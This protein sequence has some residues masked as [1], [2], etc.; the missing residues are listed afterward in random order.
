M[1]MFRVSN[2]THLPAIECQQLHVQWRKKKYSLFSIGYKNSH[3][4][5]L[6]NIYDQNVQTLYIWAS[7]Q[8]WCL[9]TACL[10]F[11]YLQLQCKNMRKVYRQKYRRNK[12]C[13]FIASAGIRRF[14]HSTW[15][16]HTLHMLTESIPNWPLS[17]SKGIIIIVLV[18]GFRFH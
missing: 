16:T 17:I 1:C 4:F 8:P 2:M 15:A 18:F 6:S 3:Q 9:F 10:T 12:K 14:P 11:I 13:S 5:Y 7:V